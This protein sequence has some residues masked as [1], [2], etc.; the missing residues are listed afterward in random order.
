M[1]AKAIGRFLPVSP[2]KVRAVTRL[3]KGLEVVQAEAILQNLRKGAAQPVAKVLHS[4]VANATQSG[5]WTREQLVVS[6]ILAD[7]GPS[8][9][10][11]RAAAR[12]Q[13]KQY[14]RRLSHLTIELDVKKDGA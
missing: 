12:G 9:K 8:G 3:L 7:E 14:R 4:A 5:S 6:R 13:A 11:V 10:R 1:V 2:R